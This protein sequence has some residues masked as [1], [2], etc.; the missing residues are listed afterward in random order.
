MACWP[1]RL[2]RLRGTHSA[3]ASVATAAAWVS[4]T[5]GVARRDTPFRKVYSIGAFDVRLCA[6]YPNTD[7]ASPIPVR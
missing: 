3:F 1:A 6:L 5:P 4:L 2:K 7:V